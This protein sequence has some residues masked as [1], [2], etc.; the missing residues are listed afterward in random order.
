MNWSMTHEAPEGK[1][2]NPCMS[3]FFLNKCMMEIK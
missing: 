3:V 2:F 1:Y